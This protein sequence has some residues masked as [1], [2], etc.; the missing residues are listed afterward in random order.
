MEP[1]ML[2]NA[3]KI[4][5]KREELLNTLQI[6][7]AERDALLSTGGFTGAGWNDFKL[8]RI[9]HMIEEIQE[10]LNPT[11][12]VITP[13]EIRSSIL[14][15]A[16]YLSAECKLDGFSM[17]Q[18]GNMIEQSAK[19]R[20]TD[21]HNQLSAAFKYRDHLKENHAFN[22]YIN[23]VL[24]NGYN[25]L[26]DTTQCSFLMPAN[27]GCTAFHYACS[28]AGQEMPIATLEALIDFGFDFNQ[29]L[30]PAG[31]TALR[32]ASFFN[33]VNSVKFLINDCLAGLY[34]T[35]LSCDE[36][37]K[38]TIA[39]QLGFDG[40]PSNTIEILL[41]MDGKLLTKASELEQLAA[42]EKFAL[43]KKLSSKNSSL[44]GVSPNILH[45]LLKELR[46]NALEN[47]C[48]GIS[49]S[50]V[51]QGIITDCLTP[52]LAVP[53]L[54]AL[55]R[56]R[57]GENSLSKQVRQQ[58]FENLYSITQLTEENKGLIFDSLSPY[59]SLADFSSLART[60]A[61]IA[62][63]VLADETSSEEEVTPRKSIP[64]P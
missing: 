54:S 64:R 57:V 56:T 28:Y 35:F 15:I 55:T 5:S 48:S 39:K 11:Y 30:N 45:I 60:Q 10:K 12:R 61:G 9:N 4:T 52:Y 20:D 43:L 19:F 21:G 17:V 31:K 13:G 7:E 44:T 25:L 2:N 38:A 14:E 29:E 46:Q 32:M 42:D 6:Y 62:K 18:L 33:H 23:F 24:G 47:V 1:I 27:N 37:R 53:A 22:R 41:P 51:Q 36:N 50:D 59:L 63:V 34:T 3:P 49:I 26:P 16:N 40:I 8:Y 58:G